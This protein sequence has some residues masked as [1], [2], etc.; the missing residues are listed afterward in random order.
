MSESSNPP[1]RRPGHIR[2]MTALGALGWTFLATVLTVVCAVFAHSIHGSSDSVVF[3]AAQ[4]IAYA[5][6]LF[7]IL[8]FY[9]SDHRIRDVIGMRA[10]SALSYPLS[11]LAGLALAM[12]A[13]KLYEVVVARFPLKADS[14][15]EAEIAAASPA[16][17]AV[18]LLGLTVVG[19]FVEEMLFRGALFTA[20]RA[21]PKS[22]GVFALPLITDG[23]E[24]G[25]SLRPPPPA[26]VAPRN[27]VLEAAIATTTLFTLVHVEW[28]KCLVIAVLAV[29]LAFL[30]VRS[31]SLLPGFL[32]HAGFNSLGCVDLAFGPFESVMPWSWAAAGLAV[33]AALLG[34]LALVFT[35]SRDAIAAR[36][37]DNGVT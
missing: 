30:R 26:P 9:A 24:A 22:G 27:A 29:S 3:L 16:R 35:R 6:T 4:A 12:P 28:Q 33:G 17:L 25:S 19:P 1:P 13:N 36:E 14:G 18:L 32:M 15:L 2:P 37:A 5:L 31:G 20:L 21:P 34:A 7:A 23:E 8:R 10:S 11:F